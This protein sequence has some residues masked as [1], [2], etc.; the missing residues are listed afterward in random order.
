MLFGADGHQLLLFI[1][2]FIYIYIYKKKNHIGNSCFCFKTQRVK[3]IFRGNYTLPTKKA[4]R[5]VEDLKNLAR[6]ETD[7]VRHN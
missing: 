1:Y 3:G 5:Y 7:F 2:L 4:K 6:K